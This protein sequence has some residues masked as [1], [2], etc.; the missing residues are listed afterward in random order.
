MAVT[1]Q[2]CQ[3]QQQN[4]AIIQ[5]TEEMEKKRALYKKIHLQAVK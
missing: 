1:P 3:L 5:V 2:I 4:P